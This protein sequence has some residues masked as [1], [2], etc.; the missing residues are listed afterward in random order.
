[1]TSDIISTARTLRTA[2]FIED[3]T[4]LPDF[5][6]SIFLK[7]LNCSKI[8]KLKNQNSSKIKIPQQFK[9]L[10]FLKNSSKIEKKW[11][12]MKDWTFEAALKMFAGGARKS[13]E[14]AGGKSVKRAVYGALTQTNSSTPSL[15]GGWTSLS[16]CC[17][18]LNSQRGHLSR[19]L[20]LNRPAAAKFLKNLKNPEKFQNS[21]KIK[22][23]QKFQEN[24]QI[25]F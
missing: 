19:P 2:T 12:K 16:S 20:K 24:F 17:T 6:I 23:L 4:I 1:M 18:L 22:I 5:N 3:E 13:R 15:R 25:G 8:S 21:S 14:K 9:N 10:N 11:G 7:N